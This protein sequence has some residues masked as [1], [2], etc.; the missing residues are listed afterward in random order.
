VKGGKK[1]GDSE[2]HPTLEQGPWERFFSIGRRKVPGQKLDE[3]KGKSSLKLEKSKWVEKVD[4]GQ[5]EGPKKI[6]GGHQS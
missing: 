4:G 5:K 3:K 6:K 2:I 1:E